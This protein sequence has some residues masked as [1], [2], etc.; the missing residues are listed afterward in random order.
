MFLRWGRGLSQLAPGWGRG[1]PGEALPPL[2]GLHPEGPGLRSDDLQELQALLLLVLP[3]LP[4]R[5][6]LLPPLHLLL[7][8][9][10]SILFL[11]LLLLL[12][13]S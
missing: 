6:D 2:P 8:L 12:L 13:T 7:L 4:G 3:G 9:L 11:L 5:E 10:P 1:R